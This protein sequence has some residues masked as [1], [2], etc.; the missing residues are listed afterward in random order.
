MAMSIAFF[1]L[2][3]LFLLE[4]GCNALSTPANT[5]LPRVALSDLQASQFR[6]KL[7]RDL[8]ETWQ[9]L[10]G[11]AVVEQGL[12]RTALTFVEQAVR[13]DLLSTAVQ[14][15]R[16]QLPDV[17]ELLV[18]ACHILDMTNAEND[19]TS[20]AKNLPELYVQSNPDR[21]VARTRSDSL[22]SPCDLPVTSYRS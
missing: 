20:S 11:H 12:R 5:P 10:P 18:E 8:T 13:L 22:G 15:S 9:R 21:S 16:E 4:T 6:H 17:Y 7:D 1:V 14:V 3:F 19:T 2:F